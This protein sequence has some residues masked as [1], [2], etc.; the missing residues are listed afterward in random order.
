MRV[1]QG[2]SANRVGW[3]PLGRALDRQLY[4]A[5]RQ[6][7]DDEALRIDLYLSANRLAEQY[8]F[9]Q[10]SFNPDGSKKL[11]TV[12]KMVSGKP[13]EKKIWDPYHIEFRGD[14]HN[15]KEA[16]AAEAP[17]LLKKVA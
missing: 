6:A 17:E 11:I 10:I 13:V 14:Y 8:G 7:W 12:I 9:R 4:D 1:A 16:I 15:L 2:R 3:H 5:K